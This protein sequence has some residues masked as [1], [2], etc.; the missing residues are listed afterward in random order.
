MKFV[1]DLDG[2]I[3][4]K[5]QPVSEKI[6]IALEKLVAAGHEVIFASARPVRDL[7]PVLHERFHRFSMIGGNG[8]MV[9]LNGKIISTVSFD[10]ETLSNIVQLLRTYSVSYLV[11]GE[12]DYAYTGSAIHPIM[13][14][15]DPQRRAKNV[16]L[17]KLQSIVKVLMLTS[18]N[19]Q[20][21]ET[22]LSRMDVVV[23]SH[24][25]EGVLDISPKGIDKWSGLQQLGVEEGGYIAFGNDANDI[26]M[27]QHAM[28][29]VMIGENIQL[30]PFSSEQLSL[31]GDTEDLIVQRLMELG[32]L[33]SINKSINV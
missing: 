21:V 4:F 25:N 27:F 31:C 8:S 9:A 13:N 24:G 16:T 1:F 22:Q 26:A 30:A 5:G 17:D 6:L 11:D 12:W 19:M 32:E 29:S 18:D 33:T 2:T 3:C 20:E 23:H 28:H 14:N 10:E 15:L 7:L